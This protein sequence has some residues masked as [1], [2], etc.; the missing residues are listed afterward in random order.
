MVWRTKIIAELYPGER[1]A[2]EYSSQAVS[3]YG[4]A[5]KNIAKMP[6]V[7]FGY[8]FHIM[9]TVRLSVD[10]NDI[11]KQCTSKFSKNFKLLHP[12]SCSVS[13]I[14]CRTSCEWCTC[15]QKLRQIFL[16]I[17]KISK[18]NCT[19]EVI[20][21]DKLSV[22]MRITDFIRGYPE[23]TSRLGANPNRQIKSIHT[24]TVRGS[25]SLK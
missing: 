23:I 7:L 19:R 14:F 1:L 24:D 11:W 3:S 6:C 15:W 20:T 13:C 16:I 17:S 25:I 5:Y 10:Q 2:C 4:L 8:Y 22:S 9:P 12:F 21:L 18:H